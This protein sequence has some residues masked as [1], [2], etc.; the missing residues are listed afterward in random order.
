MI[1]LG[2][3]TTYYDIQTYL[4]GVQGSTCVSLGGI[5][6][7]GK[8]YENASG[9]TGE[10]PAG[11]VLNNTQQQ[12]V[13]QWR[14]NMDAQYPASITDAQVADFYSYDDKGRLEATWRYIPSIPGDM[15]LTK[16]S[17]VYDLNSNQTNREEFSKVVSGITTVLEARNFSFDQKGNVNSITDDNGQPITNYTWDELGQ[18]KVANLGGQVSVTNSWGLK[19]LEKSSSVLGN[20]VLYS[21]TLI[22]GQIFPNQD[23]VKE[24]AGTGRMD[25][26]VTREIRQRAELQYELMDYG[27]D[28]SGHMSAANRYIK[29][30]AASAWASD[31]SELWDYNPDGGIHWRWRNDTTNTW[32][33]RTGSH[34]PTRV[35]GPLPRGRNADADGAF[36]YDLAGR[37]IWDWSG[38]PMW[39]EYGADGRLVKT[40][41]STNLSSYSLHDYEGWVVGEIMAYSKNNEQFLAN[42]NIDIGGKRRA[43]V[44]QGKAT[45]LAETMTMLQGVGGSVGRRFANGSKEWYVKDWRGST[46]RTV[47][48]DVSGVPQGGGW[49]FAYGTYGFRKDLKVDNASKI[50]GHQWEGKNQNDT[51]G[52]T[53]IG[54]RVWDPELAIWL[55]TDPAGQ[56]GDPYIMGGDPVNNFDRD[57]RC[58]DP[59]TF[60]ICAAVVTT[61][62]GAYI[63]GSAANHGN[64][65]PWEWKNSVNTYAGMLGGGLLGAASGGLLVAGATAGATTAFGAS[66]V[67]AGALSAVSTT[68]EGVNQIASGD[69]FDPTALSE[70]WATGAVVG[71]VSGALY[72]AGID[73]SGWLSESAVGLP[74]WTV[75][76]GVILG[77]AA[78]TGGVVGAGVGAYNGNTALGTLKGGGVGLGLGAAVIGGELV[79]VRSAQLFLDFFDINAAQLSILGK[80][81]LSVSGITP[82]IALMTI[83]AS[84]GLALIGTSL[85]GFDGDKWKQ[86]IGIAKTKS[87]PYISGGSACINE[88]QVV[89]NAAQG[90]IS[91]DQAIVILATKVKSGNPS[92]SRSGDAYY[93]DAKFSTNCIEFLRGL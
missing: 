12:I 75:S 5:I 28:Q 34:Q 45:E 83:G 4:D 18:M 39:H 46:I 69:G 17:F 37:L 92:F 53:T 9:Y 82:S 7:R 2:S 72:G 19:G 14:T 22:R 77:A 65:K 26:S 76:N 20:S 50:P 15:K 41:K 49:E 13:A 80:I 11:V 36:G 61:V 24:P 91:F 8:A 16:L 93:P 67:G 54:V 1:D 40:K 35:T 62:V 81:G 68:A 3:K 23:D 44:R 47:R 87:T 86:G 60:V 52:L 85:W 42:W 90:N 33:Y 88:A 57:G 6:L 66:L 73:G 58:L 25:G 64:L 30:G 55:S 78:G 32:E 51:L 27:W 84:P 79:T 38:G 74:S 21:E 56:F 10:L 48:T 71:A 31:G 70:A 43:E 63:G 89:I 59:V 29:T